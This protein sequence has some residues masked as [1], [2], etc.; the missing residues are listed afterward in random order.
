MARPQPN[1][2]L[3]RKVRTQLA[4][5]ADVDERTVHRF[6]TGERQTL[7]IVARAIHDAARA[8]GVDLGVSL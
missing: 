3:P 2:I 4:A 6:L 8:L 1:E 5:R 7:P